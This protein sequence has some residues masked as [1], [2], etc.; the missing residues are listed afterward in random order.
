MK[1]PGGI[2]STAWTPN[3]LSIPPQFWFPPAGI[4]GG[5]LVNAADI[6]SWSDFGPNAYAPAPIG[7]AGNRLVVATAALNGFAAAS[8]NGAKQGLV[9]PDASGFTLTNNNIYSVFAVLKWTASAGKN[10]FFGLGY[11]NGFPWGLDTNSSSTPPDQ[12]WNDFTGGSGK[13]AFVPV[14]GTYYCVVI[15]NNAGAETVYVNGTAYAMPISGVTYPTG[16]VGFTLGN[17]SNTVFPFAALFN[18]NLVDIALYNGALGL[19]DI[20]GLH[21][22]SINTYALP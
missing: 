12:L 18:G 15:V 3:T 5:T 6:T 13:S 20:T 21:T 4:N 9:V 14:F 16:Q 10:S 2:A 19:A 8:G 22:Y 7:I 1:I 11:N 17:Y